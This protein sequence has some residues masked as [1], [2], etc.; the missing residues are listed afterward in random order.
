MVNISKIANL[1]L[2]TQV[3]DITIKLLT[4]ISLNFNKE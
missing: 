2:Q 3:I 1:K 4:L